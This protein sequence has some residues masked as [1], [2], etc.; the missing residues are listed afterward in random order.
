MLP[1]Q[2]NV[3]GSCA[4]RYTHLQLEVK[5]GG[6]EIESNEFIRP[7]RCID[8]LR[9][10]LPSALAVRRVVCLF[11]CGESFSDQHELCLRSVVSPS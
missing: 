2:S 7:M 9:C 3:L 8:L 5:L 4:F 10:V 11:V 6:V 1:K